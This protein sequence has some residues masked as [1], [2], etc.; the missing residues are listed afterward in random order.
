[1]ASSRW[2]RRRQRE[3]PDSVFAYGL[4]LPSLLVTLALL[5][6][7]LVYSFWVSL[8][9]VNFG[10]TEWKFVWFDNYTAAVTNDLFGPST[11][12]TLLFATVV[13]VLTTVLGFAFAV[14][15]SEDF[16]GRNVLRGLMILPWAL[17]QIMLALTFG[18]IFNST[19]GPLNGL[20]F[21]LGII[22]EYVAWFAKGETIL[23]IMAL[24]FVW[25]LVPFATLLFLGALQ[26][27][28]EDL[29]KAARVDGAN[30]FQRLV[31]VTLPWI[32]ETILIVVVL[33]ALNGFLAFGLIFVLTG[34]G[35]GTDTTLLAWWGYTA[36]FRDL[37]L[38][39]G[40]AIFYLMTLMV[41]ALSVL[42]VVALGRTREGEA[43][44]AE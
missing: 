39:L 22:D 29:L 23:F 30:A 16:P 18:W 32:R 41:L 38:G 20:L 9:E 33:A 40:S 25:S 13:T 10:G 11:V 12:R 27:V 42:T 8:H 43:V 21:D 26:T 14:V 36:A 6:Y 1:M 3:L 4:A 7:P 44:A 34:G 28:P 31:L 17:S 24:A 19:Y 35:P 15:L 2:P 37:E 5:G